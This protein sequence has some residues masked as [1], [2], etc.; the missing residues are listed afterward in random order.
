MIQLLSNAIDLLLVIV[1]FGLV[2]FIHELGHFLAAKWAGVRVE[3]FALG[4][5]QAVASYRQGVGLCFGST[6]RKVRAL[7]KQRGFDRRP[8]GSIPLPEGV[9]P[10]EYR[11]N[12]IPFG[13][14]VKLLGQEDLGA[15]QQ[16]S[17]ADS[18]TAKPAWKRL[19]IMSGGVAMNLVLAA[20]L[21]LIV[22]LVGLK[23][24]PPAVGQVTP[25]SPADQ[26]VAVN[27]DAAGVEQAGLQPGDRIVKIG[28]REPRSFN[29]V[30]VTVAM[31][32]PNTSLP[33][34]IERP[35]APTPLHF[36][37][38]PR[39]NEA[40]RYLEIGVSPPISNRIAE[41]APGEE[42]LARWRRAMQRSGLADLEPGARL[43]AVSDQPA[44]AL[45]E[46]AEALRRSQGQPV[47]ATFKTPDGDEKTLEINP[48]PQLQQVSARIAD[49]DQTIPVTHLLGL[50]PS[51]QVAALAEG[52]RKANL[53]PGD[54][55]ARIG[56]LDWPDLAQGVG[57]IRQHAGE[58]IALTV[59]RQGEYIDLEAPVSA[60]GLIGF[61]PDSAEADLAVTTRVP[62]VSQD[63]EEFSFAAESLDLLPGTIIVSVDGE[64]VSNYFDLRV[65]LRDA[66]RSAHDA[67]QSAE[68][69]L[70]VRLP[71]GETFGAGPIE[72]TTWS[73]TADDVQALHDLG[74]ESPVDPALFEP[75]Q[76]TLRAGGP[77]E[78]VVMGVAET[79]RMVLMAYLTLV[80][81]AQGSVQ[82]DQLKGPV[83]I[84]HIGV[85][86][87]EQ[88]LIRLLFFLGLLS[89]NLAVINFLPIPIA[90]GGHAVMLLIE[91]ITRRP[92]PAGV[93]NTATM[94]GL[95]FIA[96]VFII[97]TYND[98]V[99][100]LGG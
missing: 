81:L 43:I 1:G 70:E 30:F 25:G 18:F 84:A 97:I 36:E 11:L 17:Q 59:L 80:R 57:R 26:V 28:Q 13:G 79:H 53:Q 60:Q 39:R 86:V 85:Q 8:D 27:A 73:L 45:W 72:Q 62:T 88:G 51:M 76:T 55:F 7:A 23:A 38:E 58:T 67:G 83:G 49:G 50:T 98:I 99:A 54:V 93:Q 33:V 20:G 44:E 82:V 56:S 31:A 52:G 19:V 4:F 61:S 64:P 95:I 74:W 94:L 15:D 47:Q 89:A 12:W 10:T 6:E 9:S 91:M 48:R 40:T 41:P 22:F 66:T 63:E 100:L 42:N 34:V 32:D 3:A 16:S 96:A 77:V 21:F 68:V 71:I 78:A 14:Y 46:V 65:R 37:I 92:V 29:D 69:P 87:A 90:D 5:G 75:A 35:G 2:I 24:P